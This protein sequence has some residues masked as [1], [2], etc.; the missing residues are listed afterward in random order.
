MCKSVMCIP[1]IGSQRLLPH[2]MRFGLVCKATS[3]PR[4][5]R[6]ESDTGVQNRSIF[7]SCIKKCISEIFRVCTELPTPFFHTLQQKFSKFWCYPGKN[8]V[9][10]MKNV[11]VS[12]E[13]FIGKGPLYPHFLQN[14]SSCLHQ[15]QSWRC[16]WRRC[17][18]CERCRGEE[19]WQ[20]HLHY[21]RESDRLWPFPLPPL[22]SS[23]SLVLWGKEEGRG[24]EVKGTQNEQERRSNKKGGGKGRKRGPEEEKVSD[25]IRRECVERYRLPPPIFPPYYNILPP[26]REG[27]GSQGRRVKEKRD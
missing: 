25:G 3:Y 13:K 22:L 4:G 27:Y 16:Q 23:R 11:G 1:S 17:R 21:W 9:L 6:K 2:C 26:R 10:A 15:L 8:L 14:W 20:I 19:W 24:N 18:Y 5:G 7:T 12:H